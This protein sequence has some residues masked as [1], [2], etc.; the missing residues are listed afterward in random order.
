MQERTGEG[1]WRHE[2]PLGFLGFGI[3]RSTSVVRLS[4]GGLFVHS[5][6]EL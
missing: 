6:G 2:E 4:S 1:P 3:G 5:P